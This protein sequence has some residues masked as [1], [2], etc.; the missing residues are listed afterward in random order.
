MSPLR[1]VTRAL[2]VPAGT[3]LIAALASACAST[4][5]PAPPASPPQS[6]GAAPPPAPAVQPTEVA[7]APDIL[8]LCGIPNADAYF[9]FDSASVAGKARTPLDAVAAC[10]TTGKL[11]G[12]GMKLVGRADPR[13]ASDYNMTLGQSRADA[14]A[15]Y[16]ERRGVSPSHA[17]STTRGALDATGTDESSWAHDRRVDILL[18]D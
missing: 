5:P 10:F 2:G 13:G 12:R 3:T 11:A 14:V 15:S 4:P 17:A 9:N 18:A 6:V 7:L 16:L 1:S 8:R